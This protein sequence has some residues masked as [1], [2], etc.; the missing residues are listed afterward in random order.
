MKKK[1][2]K[3]D[4]GIE[5]HNETTIKFV[6][7]QVGVPFKTAEFNIVYGQGIDKT[8]DTL[9]EAIR[10]GVIQQKGNHYSIQD[11]TFANSRG[12]AEAWI[13]MEER[14]EKIRTLIKRKQE[15]G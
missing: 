5:M 10:V 9:E 7:N 12:K 3:N 6:K 8:K 11:K 2:E 1:A 4:D 14:L 13:G 15:N